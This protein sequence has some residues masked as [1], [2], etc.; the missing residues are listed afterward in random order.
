M[1][2]PA[3]TPRNN[4]FFSCSL[5]ALT[6]L[7]LS[8]F[9]VVAPTPQAS[10]AQNFADP[11]FQQL[12][13][14]TDKLVNDGKTS[15]SFLWGPSPNSAGVLE[16]YADAPGGKRLV[17]YFDKSRMEITNPNGDKS[18]AYYVTNGLIAKELMTGQLQLGD[19]KFEQREPAALGV[20]GDPDDTSGPTYK[21]LERVDKPAASD[22]TGI[23]VA[24]F[25]DRDGNTY[26]D[27]G[28]YGNKWKVSYAYYEPSTQHN[29]AGPFWTYLNQTGPVL[30]NSGQQATG[31]IFDPVFF[32]TGLPIT[33]AYWAQ[34]KV[35]GQV[36]DVLIQAFERRVLTFTPTND[37]AYQVEMGNVGQHYYNWR[38]ANSQPV[39]APPPGTTP[40]PPSPPVT[41]P[42]TPVAASGCLP[43]ATAD[44]VQA[45]VSDANPKSGA[46]VTVYGRLVLNG[47]PIANAQMD[48]TWH[49]KSKPSYCSGTSGS[50]GIASCT[51]DTGGATKGFTV[52]VDVVFSYNGKTY[53]A[54][55]KF[56]PQ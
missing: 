17:Q 36:K 44:G 56:T 32:A 16:D 27:R 8:L 55:T 28:D 34:V 45:C 1:H 23:L 6:A 18:S 25:I 2:K 10:A 39:T 26:F 35:A 7:L 31:K 15:R 33:E 54:S 5:V 51:R 3:L 52:N 46:D 4:L 48:T 50:D 43:S 47:Q 12:W 37:P 13:N 11:Y 49:Y 42:P 22:D 19:S 29:I 40:P 21:A 20:A 38:Y 53:S 24:G 9:F 14:R 30:N 41:R